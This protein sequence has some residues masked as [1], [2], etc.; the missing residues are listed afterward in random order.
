[1]DRRISRRLGQ[2]SNTIH[3]HFTDTIDPGIFR[4]FWINASR[5]QKVASVS[6]HARLL[7]VVRPGLGGEGEGENEYERGIKTGKV[8]VIVVVV[9][10]E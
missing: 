4:Y 1:M 6:L 2:S 9:G 8:G 3:L 10:K 5:P 7:L